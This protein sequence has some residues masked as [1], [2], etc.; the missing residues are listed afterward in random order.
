MK[1]GEYKFEDLK[2]GS[3]ASYIFRLEE[4]HILN[5]SKLTGDYHPLHCCENFAKD[6][7]FKSI[8]AHGLLI[9]S[10]S[11][12]LIA[13]DIPGKN[14]ILVSQNFSYYNPAYPNDELKCNAEII[15]LDKRFSIV[16]IM[17]NVLKNNDALIAEG[18]FTLKI[19]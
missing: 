11:S 6:A 12:K 10:I 7:G 9:S 1:V 19:R 13:M 17:V 15:E 14:S 5:F 4:K 16:K 8:I 18:Y 2:I 3:G